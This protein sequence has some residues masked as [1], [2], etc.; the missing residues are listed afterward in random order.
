MLNKQKNIKEKIIQIYTIIIYLLTIIAFEIGYC[1]CAWLSNMLLK[2]EYKYNF[3]ICRIVVYITFIILYMIF[4]KTF[5]KEAIEVSKNNIKRIIFY[6]SI[7][8]IILSIIFTIFIALNEV[9]LLR[10]TIIGLI[11]VLL[12]SLF[13]LYI[14]NNCVKNVIV[15]TCTFGIVFTIVT[16]FNHALDEKR[17]FITAFNVANFNLDYGNNGIT[18]ENIEKLPQLSKFTIIDS[19]LEESYKPNII[20]VNTED[21]PSSPTSYPFYSYIFS[22][23]G[24]WTA[25]TLGGS[26]IDMYILGRIFNLVIYSILI[27]IAIKILPFKKNLFSIIAFMPMSLMLAASYSVDGLCIGV[28]FIFIAFCMKLYKEDNPVTLKQFII[29]LALFLLMLTAKSMSYILVAIVA[30]ILPIIKT[31]KKNKK[32]LPIISILAIIM[33][34]VMI[35][36]VFYIKDTKLIADTR[37]GDTNTSKQLEILLTNPKHDII[38]AINQ[39]KETLLNFNWYCNLHPS[40]FFTENSPYIMFTMMLYILYIAVTE[41]DHNFKLK[42]KIIMIISFLAVVAMTSLA[43]YI[44]FTEVGQLH[45]AGYQTRYILPILPLLLF[46]LSSKK[47]KNY[48]NENRVMNIAIGSGI[49]IFIGLL[50]LILV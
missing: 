34:I 23:L 24:I 9:I 6:F 38:L 40:A 43:M 10:A 37:G 46:C 16:N 22:A 44:A 2:N 8:A 42:N 29:L 7:I 45:V 20:N 35:F 50:Q 18:D 25:K 3:S 31:L 19:F 1:N 11:S 15:I 32:Y 4:K 5:I 47:L 21:A 36:A 14:S 27:S 30:L 39:I 48:E 17:H 41:D 13:I 28:V 26:I 49:F 12:G 33:I